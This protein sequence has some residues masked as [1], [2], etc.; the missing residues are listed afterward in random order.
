MV[1]GHVIRLRSEYPQVRKGIV[2]V[3]P[4]LVVDYVLRLKRE[5]LA[6][7]CAGSPLALP[8]LAVTAILPYGVVTLPRAESAAALFAGLTNNGLAAY[9][10][11]FFC[12]PNRGNT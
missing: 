8:I 3:V 4:V 10:A 5:A 6:N 2:S 11:G 7:D 1:V 9:F 12:G